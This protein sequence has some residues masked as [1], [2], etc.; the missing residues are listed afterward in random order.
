MIP[1]TTIKVVGQERG[2][3]WLFTL[4]ISEI[5]HSHLTMSNSVKTYY[6]CSYCPEQRAI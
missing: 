3:H 6:V 4:S 1:K 2:D 5:V